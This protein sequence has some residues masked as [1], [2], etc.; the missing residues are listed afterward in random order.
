MHGT[1]DNIPNLAPFGEFGAFVL[2]LYKR[3]SDLEEQI[4][5]KTEDDEIYFYT[6]SE[7][8][9]KLKVSKTSVYRL[10]EDGCLKTLGDFR[11]KKISKES[12]ENYIKQ[13]VV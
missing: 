2:S 13:F 6:V 8:A 12:L 7:A 10:I 5:N 11:H 1:N 4:K 9:A 3:I